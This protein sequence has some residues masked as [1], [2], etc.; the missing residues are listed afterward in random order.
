MSE[1]NRQVAAE[2]ALDGRWVNPDGSVLELEVHNDGRVTGTFTL[3]SDWPSYRP[4]RVTGTYS[5]RPEGGRGVVGSVVGWP[6]ASS[7][8]VW[9]A[10]YDAGT[11]ELRTTWLLAAGPHDVGQPPPTVGG[12]VFHRS[13]RSRSMARAG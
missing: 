12:A 4:H 5:S 9:T 8:T 6:N 13:P 1:V 3:G 7:V 2:H 10:E 11:G